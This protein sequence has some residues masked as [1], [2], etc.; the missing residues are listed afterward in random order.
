MASSKVL[1][2]KGITD[3]VY[4]F[5]NDSATN[6]NFT[7]SMAELAR[8]DQTISGTPT[9][10]ISAISYCTSSIIKIS[11]GGVLQYY[12]SANSGEMANAYATDYEN[13]DQ[14]FSI[15]VASGVV[16]IRILKGS[17][18]KQA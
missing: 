16:E 4:R 11:R 14:P 3:V 17:E 18:Y 7:V 1:I 5:V 10:G 2:K 6:V 12:F 8:S 9:A 13:K 15:D